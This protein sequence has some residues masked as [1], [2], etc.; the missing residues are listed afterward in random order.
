[1]RRYTSFGMAIWATIPPHAFRGIRHS[2]KSAPDRPARLRI[3]P[4]GFH[5]AEI[6][7]AAVL[8]GCVLSPCLWG[9][10]SLARCTTTSG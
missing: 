4:P 7:E 3:I 10:W 6:V 8:C 5:R 1:V 2:I 9:S